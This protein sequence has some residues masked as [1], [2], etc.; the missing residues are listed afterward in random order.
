MADVGSGRM[1]YADAPRIAAHVSLLLGV[2]ALSIT[3]QIELDYQNKKER[4]FKTFGD[5]AF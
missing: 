1:D 4:S 5:N 2:A 3:V